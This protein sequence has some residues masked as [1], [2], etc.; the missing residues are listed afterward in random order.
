[1]VI[2][3]VVAE[4]DLQLQYVSLRRKGSDK[5]ET[6]FS[7]MQFFSEVCVHSLS[8]SLS[9]FVRV[10]AF[11]YFSSNHFR[12]RKQS[13]FFGFII[14]IIERIHTRPAGPVPRLPRLLG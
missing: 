13:W 14:I 9:L 5:N 6:Y 4:G 7:D 1:M 8:L 11:S 2:E 10:C 3:C 12:T